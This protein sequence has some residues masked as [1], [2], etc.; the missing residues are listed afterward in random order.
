MGLSTLSFS[1]EPPGGD[2]RGHREDA[3]RPGRDL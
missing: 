2:T 3:D 1:A